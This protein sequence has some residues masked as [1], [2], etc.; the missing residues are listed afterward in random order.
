MNEGRVHEQ[1]IQHTALFPVLKRLLGGEN[2]EG[3]LSQVSIDSATAVLREPVEILQG[4]AKVSPEATEAFREDLVALRGEQLK[5]IWHSRGRHEAY[6]L[7]Q[8]PLEEQNL[9]LTDPERFDHLKEQAAGLV[10]EASAND[11]L[12]RMKDLGYY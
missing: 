2:L 4:L 3:A 9:Y 6:Q 7:D 12:Q 11:M 5:F 10:G 1:L 8:D